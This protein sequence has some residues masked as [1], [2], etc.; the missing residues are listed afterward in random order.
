[1]SE[2]L[3]LNS[4]Y[5]P[6][7]VTSL[8]RGFRLVFKGKAEIVSADVL[9]PIHTAYKEFVRPLIIR[10]LNYVKYRLRKIRTNRRRLYQRDGNR[11]GYCNSTHTLT[12][13]HV[14]P[15]SKGGSNDWTNIVT[16]CYKCNLKKADRTPQEAEMTLLVKLYEP[17][18]M[19]EGYNKKLT[20]AWDQLHSTWK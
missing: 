2:V 5:V 20:E 15:K 1:M 3:V 17:V 11:C 14:I 6:I 8:H 13:D 12:I 7:N 18:F 4:D 16:C 19:P 10:L 9:H